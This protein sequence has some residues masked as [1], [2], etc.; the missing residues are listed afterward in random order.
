V[1]TNPSLRETV[2]KLIDEA[3][4]TPHSG[5]EVRRLKALGGTIT[6]AAVQAMT[7]VELLADG[8]LEDGDDLEEALED[9]ITRIETIEALWEQR[10]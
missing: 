4:A 6:A 8:K 1:S 5:P 2:D 7:Y 3:V 9:L 10:T